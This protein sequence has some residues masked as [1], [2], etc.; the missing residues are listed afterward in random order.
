MD[1][2][3]V[4]DFIGVDINEAIDEYVQEGWKVHTFTPHWFPA[5][6]WNY[7]VLFER[8]YH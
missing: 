2:Y 1:R 4:V 5:G 8:N 7:T 6:G 3:L